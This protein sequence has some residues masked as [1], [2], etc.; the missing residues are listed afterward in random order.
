[1]A[2]AE[3]FQAMARGFNASCLPEQDRLSP[4]AEFLA[5]VFLGPVESLPQFPEAASDVEG[6]PEG[7]QWSLLILRRPG[8]PTQ[9]A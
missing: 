9:E 2:S 3:F 6:E 7:G 1:M 8:V 4:S 5:E